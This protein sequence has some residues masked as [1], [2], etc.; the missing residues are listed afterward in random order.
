MTIRRNLAAA[1]LAAALLAAAGSAGVASVAAP[2][3]PSPSWVQSTG[4]IAQSSPSIFS[5]QG[6]TDVAVGDEDGRVWV[7]DLATGRSLP[8]WPEKMA[9]APG[10]V[11]AIESSPTVAYLHG[12]RRPPEVIVTSGSTWRTTTVGEVE[13]FSIEGRPLW[14]FRVGRAAGTTAGVISTPAVGPLLANGAEDVVFGAWDHEIYGLDANGRLLPGFPFD[15]ADTIWSSPALAHLP[16]TPGDAIFLGSDASGLVYD[17]AGSR[18]VGGFVGRYAYD[19]ARVVPVWRDCEPQVVWSSPVVATGPGGRALVLVGTG[20]YYSPFPTGT[21]RL[22]GLFAS[23]GR[24]A[25][26][27]PARTAGPVLGTPAVGEIA[28]GRIGVVDTTWVCTGMTP[29]S[30]QTG[31]SAV[32]AWTLTGRRLWSEQVRGEQAFGSPILTPLDAAGSGNGALDGVLVS[33]VGGLYPLAGA[34]GAYLDGTSFADAVDSGC[35]SLNSPAVGDT[36]S[37]WFVVTACGGPDRPSRLVAYRLDIPAGAEPA[38]PQ[39]R[40][41][42]DH[43]GTVQAPGKAG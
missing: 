33:S 3:W 2:D 41:N 8:G 37:G 27:W 22:L 7:D 39:F 35:E 6:Q 1:L 5:F 34:N 40:D 12:P 25:P 23:N 10:Q 4:P 19:G 29:S 9:A 32:D 20:F 43:T 18:C 42:P 38:W 31:R 26:G 21:D 14:T 17:A 24:P 16:G 11:V 15:N 30:C 28:P 36:S 13:A